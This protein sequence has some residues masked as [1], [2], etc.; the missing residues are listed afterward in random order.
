MQD[1]D[2]HM[3]GLCACMCLYLLWLPLY[4]NVTAPPAAAAVLSRYVTS[5]RQLSAS[6]HCAAQNTS[7]HN[8]STEQ[9]AHWMHRKPYV[10]VESRGMRYC[11]ITDVRTLTHTHTPVVLLPVPQPPQGRLP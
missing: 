8:R 11:E 9:L 4:F 7:L 5:I 10:A 2:M 6:T 3:Q 1:C